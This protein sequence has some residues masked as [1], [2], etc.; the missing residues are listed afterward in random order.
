MIEGNRILFFAIPLGVVLVS[1]FL[2]R[3]LL[4]PRMG[5]WLFYFSTLTSLFCILVVGLLLVGAAA[6]IQ[7]I[8]KDSG[9]KDV[10]TY[11]LGGVALVLMFAGKLLLKARNRRP[12]PAIMRWF[13]VHSFE[14]RVG[15]TLPTGVPVNDSRRLAFRAVFDD[16]YGDD[17][18]YGSVQGWGVKACC[19]RLLAIK[20]R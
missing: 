5:C 6:L 4:L 15:R 2:M 1:W 20:N 3:T 13:I 11:L 17:P 16:N 12:F 19:K 9:Q 8:L 7:H 18:R 10:D 14:D